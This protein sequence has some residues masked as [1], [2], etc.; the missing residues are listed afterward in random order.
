[1]NFRFDRFVQQLDISGNFLETLDQT[2]LQDVGESSLEILNASNSLINYIHEETFVRQSKLQTVDLS[3]NQLVVIEPNTFK[4]NRFLKTLSLAN[5]ELLKLPEGD[6]FLN[7]ISLIVLDLS[8]CNLSNIPPNTFRQLPNL[9][10]LY[11]SHNNFKVMPHL[12]NVERLITLDVSHNYLTD[13]NS[14]VFSASPKLINL[15]LSYNKLSTLNTKVMSQLAN[16]SIPE[17]LKGNP[18]LCDCALYTVYSLCSSHCVDL[19]IVCSSPQKCN[20]KLWIDCYKAG[21]DVTD[22]GVDQVEKMVTIG[23]TAVPSEW[24]EN[25]GNQKASN[26]SGIQ[27]QKEE[28]TIFVYIFMFLALPVLVSIIFLAIQK[29]R[30]RSRPLRVTGPAEDDSEI[31]LPLRDPN[32]LVTRT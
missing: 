16:V 30:S 2:S 13:V 12:Q 1:M 5:N 32:I 23:Y 22:I 7:T 11:I 29:Y 9:E 6:S 25:H 14:E 18:W 21:C 24:L 19:E 20:D 10:T 4:H 15:N 28:Y 3:R 26:S 31:C 17:D 27:M 8:A